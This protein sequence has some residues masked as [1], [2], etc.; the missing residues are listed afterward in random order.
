MATAQMRIGRRRG[1]WVATLCGFPAV[2]SE[3][4]VATRIDFIEFCRALSRRRSGFEPVA[5]VRFQRVGPTTIK[6]RASL[7][8]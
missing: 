3:E 4:K 6:V 7:H 1:F 5:P 2:L 8:R